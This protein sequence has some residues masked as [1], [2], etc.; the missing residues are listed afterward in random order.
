MFSGTADRARPS[1]TGT[2]E[3][4][5]RDAHD[6]TSA[7]AAAFLRQV[8]TVETAE[9]LFTTVTA[10][11]RFLSEAGRWIVGG[12]LLGCSVSSHRERSATAVSD[13]RSSLD[14]GGGTERDRKTACACVWERAFTR[15]SRYADGFG[16]LTSASRSRSSSAAS[17]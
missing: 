7:G 8:V 1:T 17:A 12:A 9:E 5:I 10:Q 6:S 2:N 3:F 4:G 14:R 15:Y 11:P 16:L 13:Q